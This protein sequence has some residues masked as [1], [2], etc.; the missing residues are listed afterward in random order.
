[1]KQSDFKDLP[2]LSVYRYENFLNIYTDTDDNRFYNLLRSI[3]ILPANNSSA[4]D[5]YDVELNDTWI[6]ISYKYY[7]TIYL[8]WLVCEYN[9]IQDASKMPEAGTR[10]KLLKKDLVAPVL[11]NLIKQI[12]N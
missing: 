4:E 10:I 2:D 11:S 5:E 1:M 3:N 8:W 9:R 7:G 6:L 12:N